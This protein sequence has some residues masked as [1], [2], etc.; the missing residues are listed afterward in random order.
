M[1]TV[2]ILSP[3]AKLFEGE[4]EF[5]SLPGADGSLGILQNHAPIITVLK[6]GQVK[7]RNN[8]GESTFDVKGGTVEVLNNR[9]IILAQ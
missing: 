8:D 3:E 2:E 1:M 4:A 7:I 5:I 9:V 6:E